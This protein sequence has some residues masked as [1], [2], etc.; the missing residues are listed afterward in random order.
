MSCMAFCTQ[1]KNQI[2]STYK[3]TDFLSSQKSSTELSYLFE[4][5][6]TNFL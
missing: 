2:L 4:Q 3:L 6:S 1:K 5:L